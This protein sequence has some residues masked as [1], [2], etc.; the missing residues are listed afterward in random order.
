MPGL[1]GGIRD[2]PPA[3]GKGPRVR[4]A[5]GAGDAVD[6][7]IGLGVVGIDYDPILAKVIVHAETRRAA[8]ARMRRALSRYVILGVTTNLRLLRRIVASDEF[9]Q[10]QLDTAFLSRLPTDLPSK[11]PPAAI[12]AAA[13]AAR[14]RSH[15]QP[16]AA[17]GIPDP[18][19]EASGWRSR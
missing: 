15:R 17:T 19:N 18:W 4:G 14:S 6:S 12:A 7:G 13:W 8:V 10:G 2:P 1:R 5:I 16:T 9:E 11:P 3:V